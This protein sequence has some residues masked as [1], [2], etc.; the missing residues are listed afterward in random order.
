[1]ERLLSRIGA[2]LWLVPAVL[3]LLAL[4][5]SRCADPAGPLLDA[6]GA[7]LEQAWHHPTARDSAPAADDPGWR[8]VA[9]PD[10][11][12]LARRAQALDGWYRLAFD[13]PGSE[14]WA[15]SVEGDWRALAVVLNGQPQLASPERRTGLVPSD[16]GLLVALSP[17]ALRAGTNE[18]LVRYAAEASRIGSFG[19]VSIG[20]IDAIRVARDRLRLL[21]STLPTSF[22]WFALAC[23]VLVALLARF[24]GTSA[25]GWFAAGTMAWCVPLI[26]PLR[27]LTGGSDGF[28]GSVSLHAFPPL[29]AIGLHRALAVR[30][31]RLERVLLGTIGAGAGLRLLVPPLLVPAVDWTW[32]M[33]NIAIGAYVLGLVL[34]GHRAGALPRGSALLAGGVMGL[35]AG[36]HDVASLVAGYP[37]VGFALSPYAPAVLGLGTAATLVRSLG[38]RLAGAHRLNL[39]LEQRVE[40]KRREL[41]D[42]FGRM[43]DL[44]RERAIAAERARLM[45][46]M[47]DGTG[48]QLISALAMVEAGGFARDAVAEVLREALA[49]LRFSIDSLDPS[50]PDLLSLLGAARARVE[51]RLEA[52]GLSFSW[53]VCDIGPPANFGP[54]TALQVLRIFQ[55]AVVNALRHARG[56]VLTVRTGE[57][58]DAAGSWIFV[59]VVDDGRGF[60]PGA[61]DEASRTGG[62]RGLGNMR[63]RAAAIGGVLTV[64]STATGTTVRLRLPRA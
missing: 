21:H 59:E 41:A 24:E 40:E 29:F 4:A 12:G 64:T 30:R 36:L 15:L 60:E 14:S 45:R 6:G 34:R 46:D 54:G 52:Q 13:A 55:E 5:S 18:L 16:P 61:P 48:G 39:E 11:W 49:D 38:D 20:P 22:A 58:R 3:L 25:A 17:T 26:E 1:M 63:R 19:P 2:G 56:Q 50:E 32:W 23:G 35:A 44:E 62:G 37:L 57:E 47:H 33:L 10:F 42:S 9:L 8:V 53:Q 43:A 7:R 28:A 31:P 51:P 27:S